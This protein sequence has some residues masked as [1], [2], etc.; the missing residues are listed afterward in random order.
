MCLPKLHNFDIIFLICM[1]S[2]LRWCPPQFGCLPFM[3]CK[4]EIVHGIVKL[5]I[6]RN[7][8]FWRKSISQFHNKCRNMEERKF[9]FPMS[10]LG[11]SGGSNRTVIWNVMRPFLKILGACASNLFE[12]IPRTVQWVGIPFL[13]I[14]ACGYKMV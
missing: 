14:T 2:I 6:F 4:L 7:D 9:I 13:H 11:Q 5:C 8:L 10:K 3:C 1:L 12:R